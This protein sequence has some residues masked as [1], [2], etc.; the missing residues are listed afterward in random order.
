M[1]A[2]GQLHKRKPR[3]A[4]LYQAAKLWEL[5]PRNPTISGR[6]T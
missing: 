4:A 5:L 1:K 6:W 3:A 2:E